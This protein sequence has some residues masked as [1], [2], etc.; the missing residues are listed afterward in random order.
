MTEIG[1]KTSNMKTA[2]TNVF[3]ANVKKSSMGINAVSVARNAPAP[4]YQPLDEMMSEPIYNLEWLKDMAFFACQFERCAEE[5]SYPAD[6]LWLWNGLPICEYCYDE[7]VI[8]D[9]DE[10]PSLS[11]LPKFNPFDFIESQST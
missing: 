7:E 10:K 5:H 3:A 6:M 2:I 1:L 8:M 11:D 4:T 9:C